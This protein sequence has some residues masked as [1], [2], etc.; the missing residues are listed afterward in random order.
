MIKRVSLL[1]LLLMTHSLSHLYSQEKIILSGIVE[2]SIQKPL[3]FANVVVLKKNSTSIFTYAITDELGRFRVSIIKDSAYVL[4]ASFVGFKET[5]ID[6]QSSTDFF[7]KITLQEA[8][9]LDAVTIVHEMPIRISGDTISYKVDVFTN[10]KERKLEDVMEK[11][12]GFQVDEDGT[13][14]VQGKK[15]NKVIVD[16]KEFFSG[17]TKLATKNIPANVIDKINVLKNFNAIEPLRGLNNSQLVVDVR[18][19]A[20]KKNIVFGSV[21][22]GGGFQDR[23]FGHTNMFYF[24]PKFS[25]NFI[26]DLNNIGSQPLTFNDYFKFNGGIPGAGKRGESSMRL[27]SDLLGLSALQE[28]RA[29]QTTSKLGAFNFTYNPSQKLSFSGF[30][31]RSNLEYDLRSEVLRTYISE[32]GNTV[33]A[34]T[35]N[36]NQGS[37]SEIIKISTNYVPNART[38]ITYDV[39]FKSNKL[40][41]DNQQLSV[42]DMTNNTIASNTD[43]KP[44]TFS[45]KLNTY[46]TKDERNIFSLETSYEFEEKDNLL[47][48]LLTDQSFGSIIPL[49]DVPVYNIFQDSY[50]KSNRFNAILNH[51]Y[52]L[53]KM[54]HLNFYLGGY[55]QHQELHSGISERITGVSNKFLDASLRNDVHYNFTDL[56]AGASIRNKLNKF[57]FDLG[58]SLHSYTLRNSQFLEEVTFDKV[59][60]LPNL[61]VRYD[62]RKSR[63]LT[64]EYAIK[65]EFANIQDLARG[66]IIQ[67][68][69]SIFSGN[70]FLEN[71]WFHDLSLSFYDFNAYNFTNIYAVLNYQKKY[72]EISNSLLFE[73]ITSIATP[74]NLH[75]QNEAFTG[76]INYD[77]RFKKFKIKTSA[78]LTYLLF[79]NISD[80][81][82][83]ENTSF[84]QRYKASI[85]TT[86]DKFPIVEFGFEKIINKYESTVFNSQTFSVDRP[87]AS[88]EISFLKNFILTADYEFN[89]YRSKDTNTESTYDF[90]NAYL[91]YQAK[92]SPF[93]IKLSGLNLLDTKSLRRDAFTGNFT[94]TSQYFVQPQFFL[95]SL[96]YNF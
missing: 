93:E 35:S 66:S 53:N 27:S 50:F 75:V 89:F 37:N 41:E 48:L 83:I 20:D 51:Y 92:D 38:H 77:K 7:K 64:L 47:E 78:N 17:D 65:A 31:I 21:E 32:T 76:F 71:V 82:V 84:N 62:L 14:K 30:L 12:P 96:I 22:A 25:I 60:V 58:V 2:D 43:K 18:L 44:V 49:T 68:Y 46:Y 34:L 9:S 39:F 13:I 67:G 16:G 8:N 28:N 81:I 6:I 74:V 10:G 73:G 19:K 88:I 15:V 29:A 33:E 57:T 54:N 91:Y 79:N 52:V 59:L 72:D 45:Q 3:E 4:K 80:Q 40:F 87:F 85:E 26:G 1:F 86:I 11:L 56:Y 63:N 23:Y 95:L 55:N 42:F 36:S 5:K 61:K 90:L 24:N 94:N 69:N 70:P